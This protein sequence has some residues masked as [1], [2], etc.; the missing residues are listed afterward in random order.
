M[1]SGGEEEVR[2]GSPEP[3]MVQDEKDGGVE[4]ALRPL[5]E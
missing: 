1:G 5:G 4:E 2:G 3:G